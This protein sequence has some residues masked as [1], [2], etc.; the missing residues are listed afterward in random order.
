MTN[1]S[2]ITFIVSLV[3]L[4][5]SSGGYYAWFSYVTKQTALISTLRDEVWKKSEDSIRIE[6]DKNRDASLVKEEQTTQGYFVNTEDIV[7]FLESLQ[8][9]GKSL[10]TKVEVVSVDASKNTKNNTL[11]LS[12]RITGPFEGVVRTLG[13]FEN[14]PVDATLS[15]LTLD[16]G[17]AQGSSTPEWVAATTLTVGIDTSAKV[18]QV[19]DGVPEPQTVTATTSVRIST[20]TKPSL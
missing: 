17:G 6:K 20:T 16:T 11:T 10:G 15:G 9:E 8:K 2:F 7:S 1:K 14:S 3:L 13:A 19:G 18:R 5:A 4:V 12:L